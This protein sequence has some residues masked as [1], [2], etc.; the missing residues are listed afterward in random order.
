M[1][2]VVLGKYLSF[3]CLAGDCPSTCC[4]GWNIFVDDRDY[5]A[6]QELEQVELREDILSHIRKKGK[7]YFFKN[8][9]DGSCAMLDADGLCRIQRNAS[10]E[11]LCN[12]CRKYPRL[13]YTA[14]E[15][16]YLSMAASCPVVSEYLVQ[17]AVEWLLFQERQTGEGIKLSVNSLALVREAWKF[18]QGNLQLARAFYE[19]KGNEDVLGACLI[20]LADAVLDIVLACQDKTFRLEDFR[21][22]E[23]TEVDRLCSFL[24]ESSVIWEQLVKNY[25]QYRVLSRRMECPMERVDA[26][27]KQAQGELLLLRALAFG[28]YCT[29]NMLTAEFFCDLLQRVYRFCVHGKRTAEAFGELLKDFFSQD[30]LWSYMLL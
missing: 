22:P 30:I 2:T 19:E 1:E 5:R 26:S 7:Q 20:K 15:V 17:D 25:M 4:A 18:Y 3:R 8:R 10:E 12:T 29:G 23:E 21:F 27:V 28:R 24:R 6:F 9:A 11:T 14:Q 13:F 16:L